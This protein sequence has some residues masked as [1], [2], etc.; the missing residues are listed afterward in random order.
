LEISTIMM[1]AF[2]V[3]LALMSWKLYA[4]L[5]NKPLRD[6]DTTPESVTELE[7]IMLECITHSSI[8]ERELFKA[9]KAHKDF[10]QKHYWR[11]NE[12]RLK[13]LLNNFCVKNKLLSNIEDIYRLK[14]SQK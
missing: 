9:M 6:D 2:I 4:F 5:P 10:D 1:I 13:H 8:C 11:F 3:V 7:R 12:N 14:I